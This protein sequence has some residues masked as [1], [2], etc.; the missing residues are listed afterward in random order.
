MR[1]IIGFSG[2]VLVFF[3]GTVF[4]F[5]AKT[6]KCEVTI[7]DV[8]KGTS[9]RIIHEFSLKSREIGAQKK[10]F[11]LPGGDYD[12]TLSFF[13]LRRGTALSCEYK[14]SL[15]EIFFQSDRSTIKE[16]KPVNNLS[17]RHKGAFMN[18]QTSCR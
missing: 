15:G 8:L 18:I 11:K 6:A 1:K 2:F 10:N 12:C 3:T 5:K 13:G 14:Q 4:A 9:S 7:E 16:K 17:F